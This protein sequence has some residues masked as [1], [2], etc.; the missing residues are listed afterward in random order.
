MRREIGLSSWSAGSLH[1]V[2][3]EM[4]WKGRAGENDDD[5]E[6]FLLP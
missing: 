5:D 1:K 4:R 6:K 3:L 2:G